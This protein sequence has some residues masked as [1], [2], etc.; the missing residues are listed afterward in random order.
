MTN[1]S[2]IR[3]LSYH[4]LFLYGSIQNKTKGPSHIHYLELPGKKKD[5]TYLLPEGP[6]DRLLA[7]F[8]RL[9]SRSP[10]RTFAPPSLDPLVVPTPPLGCITSPNTAPETDEA[11]AIAQNKHL[12]TLIFEPYLKLVDQKHY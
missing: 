3:V 10:V 12:I 5:S 2:F 1:N 6:N 7:R 8:A 11:A 4:V 9:L